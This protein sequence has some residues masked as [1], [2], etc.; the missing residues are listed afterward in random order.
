MAEYPSRWTDEDYRSRPR[1]FDPLLADQILERLENGEMLPE[2]CRMS[3]SL[4]L[5][6]T[7]L[8]WLEEDQALADRYARSRRLGN[9]VNFDEI[10]AEARSGR[11]DAPTRV[12]ALK[13][14]TERSEPEKYGPR[15][16][17][18]NVDVPDDRPA[19]IDHAAEFRRRIEAMAARKAAARE[20]ARSDEA[21]QR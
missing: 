6:A 16:T 20:A 2:I 3:L 4:P 13:H 17:N 1:D 11:P 18:R 21:A 12:A 5:P 7:F 15:V 10:V 14:H 19:G 8:R 9:E